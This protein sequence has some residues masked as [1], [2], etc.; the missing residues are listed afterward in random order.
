[1]SKKFASI[2]EKLERTKEIGGALGLFIMHYRRS[3]NS[4]QANKTTYLVGTLDEDS[5]TSKYP[6]PQNVSSS[7]I[8]VFSYTN[9]RWRAIPVS[10]V[11]GVSKLQGLGYIPDLERGRNGR[12]R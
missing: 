12:G 7:D 4:P 6:K 3:Q 1:M 9:N 10:R 8:L 5:Y 2:E 11:A